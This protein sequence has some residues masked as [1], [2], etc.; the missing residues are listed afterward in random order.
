MEKQKNQKPEESKQTTAES[1]KEITAPKIKEEQK[2]ET[3]KKI[4]IKNEQKSEK[5]AETKKSEAQNK[6]IIKKNEAAVNIQNAP[7]STKYSMDICKF[8][9]NKPIKKAISDLEQVLSYKRAIPMR[10]GFGHQ[11]STKKF[12][13]G[14]GKYPIDASKYFIKLLKSLS[15][16]AAANGLENPIIAEAFGNIGQQPRAR[17]GKWERKRT[18]ISLTAREKIKKKTIKPKNKKPEK[19]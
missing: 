12:A 2:T 13:S 11:K 15:A 7:I 6:K 18:H 3:A 4:E 14:S 8:I 1:P 17:F 19:K 9:K 16:N 10:G 5:V